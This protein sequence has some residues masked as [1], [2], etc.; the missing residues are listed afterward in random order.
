MLKL[1]CL[2]AF[3]FAT[4]LGAVLDE[5]WRE[6]FV[7]M[8]DEFTSFLRNNCSRELQVEPFEP[9]FEL[10]GPPVTRKEYRCLRPHERHK[11]HDALQKT[12]QTRMGN[13]SQYEYFQR[14]HYGLIPIRYHAS[15]LFAPWHRQFNHQLVRAQLFGI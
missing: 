10:Q 12:R 1:Q 2:V 11:F 9:L 6:R 13:L 5:F 14:V 15:P 8:N 3:W 4:A 7:I